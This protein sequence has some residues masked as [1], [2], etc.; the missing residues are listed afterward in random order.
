ML[1]RVISMMLVVLLFTSLAGCSDN[2]EQ[3]NTK[4]NQQSE[5]K[6]GDSAVAEKEEEPIV[7]EWMGYNANAQP[8]QDA[9]TIL[10]LEEKLNVDFDIWQMPQENFD[11]AFSIRLAAG[12]M[13]DVFKVNIKDIPNYQK[14]GILGELPLET[15]FDTCPTLTATYNE[16]SPDGAVWQAAKYKGVNYGMPMMSLNG[17]YGQVVVWRKDWLDNIGYDKVPETL[18]EFED[19]LYKFRHNDPDQNG[20]KD[21]YGMSDYAQCMIYGAFG[22]GNMSKPKYAG[23]GIMLNEEEL[24]VFSITQPGMREALATMA[25]WYEK[26]IIDP[27]FVTSEDTSGYWAVSEAFQNSRIGLTSRSFFYHW[28]DDPEND[29]EDAENVVTFGVNNPDGEYVFGTPPVGPEGLSGTSTSGYL[30]N[31]LLFTTKCTEDPRKVEKILQMWEQSFVGN[32]EDPEMF[33][34][35]H[36]GIE[37]LTFEYD[38]NGKAQ[39]LLDGFAPT[40]EGI[41]FELTD[42]K[43]ELDLYADKYAFG[44]LVSPKNPY[45][46]VLVSP[47]EEYSQYKSDL[48]RMGE[49]AV[50]AI[51]TGEQPIEYYDEFIPIF[52]ENGGQEV[53]DAIQREW[54]ANQN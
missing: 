33:E 53:Q 2:D 7:I 13:P 38:E 36:H 29:D 24:P 18:E 14:Q 49:E 39:T 16:Y 40:E 23:T 51:I 41:V 45:N 3:V 37:G 34:L 9:P 10:R 35:I 11:E 12:D 42:P 32:D 44:D 43:Y 50:I 5:K 8:K 46:K 6:D 28:W 17:T 15:I 1:K 25:D 4:D 47:T 20:E 21:T 52:L 26:E 30:N 31:A 22:I 19:A 27:E 54:M 48:R